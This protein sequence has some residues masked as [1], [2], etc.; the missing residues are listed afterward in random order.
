MDTNLLILINKKIDEYK[1]EILKYQI[2]YFKK[3]YFILNINTDI[4]NDN[5]TH[6]FTFDK[7]FENI[8]QII[9][10]NDISY[11]NINIDFFED[12]KTIVDN[13]YLTKN[14]YIINNFNK[15]ITDKNITISIKKN[16]YTNI[17]ENNLFNDDYDIEKNRYLELDAFTDKNWCKCQLLYEDS[18]NTLIKNTVLFGLSSIIKKFIQNKK[19]YVNIYLLN[20]TNINKFC[21]NHLT[22]SNKNIR[23]LLLLDIKNI[24]NVLDNLDKIYNNNNCDFFIINKINSFQIKQIINK[25]KNCNIVTLINNIN[26]NVA[27]DITNILYDLINK[28]LCGHEQILFVKNVDDKLDDILINIQKNDVFYK[29]YI[30]EKYILVTSY[31][32]SNINFDKIS[33]FDNNLYDIILNN[34]PNTDEYIYCVNTIKKSINYQI[35]DKSD[36]NKNNYDK[37]NIYMNLKMYDD[38]SKLLDKMI[39][40]NYNTYVYFDLIKK[41]VAL[42]VLTEQNI[43]ANKINIL[44]NSIDDESLLSD[45]CLLSSKCTNKVL[46]EKAFAKLIQIL[47]KKD[48]FNINAIM[49]YFSLINAITE[50]S[51]ITILLDLSTRID[52]EINKNKEEVNKEEVNKEEVNKEEVNKEINCL[53]NI[54]NKIKELIKYYLRTHMENDDLMTQYENLYDDT[55]TDLKNCDKTKITEYVYEKAIYFNTYYDSI[56]KMKFN[57]KNIEDNL[58]IL[59]DVYDVK[60]NLTNV[61]RFI[62]N[63]FNLSYQG[64]SSR[65]IFIKKAKLLRK[66][67]PELNYSIDTSFKNEKINICFHAEQLN[68]VHSV[69]KDRH[70]V[71]TQLSNDDRFNVYFTTFDKLNDQVK[72]S[73][74]K[75]KHIK[76]SHDLNEIKNTLSK[77]KLDILCYCEIG[78]HPISY[79]MAFMKLAKIQINSWGHSDTSGIDSVDYFISSKLYELPYEKAQ[80]HYSEKLILLDSMST[81]YINP[82]TKYKHNMFKSRNQLGFTEDCKIFFCAQSGFKLTPFFDEYI[83]Q[84]LKNNKN[85]KIILLHSSDIHKVLSRFNDSQIGNQ[86]VVIPGCDHF[87]YMNYINV[88]NVILDPYPFGGCNSSLEAFSLCKP[89]VTQ[90]SDMINGRFTYGFYQK[91]NIYDLV[92]N[93]MDEYV[94]LITKLMQDNNF[95]ND[96]IEKISQNKDKLF[97]EEGTISDWKNLMVNLSNNDISSY[98][99]ILD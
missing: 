5:D 37:L 80:E 12:I 33:D 40:L 86:I 52:K 21:E 53:N 58:D 50:K 79:F 75:A 93:S 54:K 23:F 45:I 4:L 38:A 65:N 88:C 97:N 49:I 78:M 66:I 56:E 55:V 63:N 89:V 44:I 76:L 28:Y 14:V 99:I 35:I 70:Q 69:Y 11:I 90:P 67:C 83:I 20:D 68:R 41:K 36:I 24:Y 96:I 77:L 84:I 74:G 95:Y 51:T 1:Q 81:Y 62:P 71:I 27:N 61:V 48:M 19:F 82:M 13:V 2:N 17:F 59:N 6:E 64:M 94:N 34:L 39:E 9:I 18:Y 7:T 47:L 91:M 31:N 85:A 60:Y 8:K 98:K 87:T 26:N 10:I 92:A 32:L 30:R 46:Y 73:F 43:D 22:T 16:I 29:N 3:N 25:F 57:R 72:F 42:E 15:T